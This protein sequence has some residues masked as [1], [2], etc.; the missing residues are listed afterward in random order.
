MPTPAPP[1]LWDSGVGHEQQLK[2]FIRI[3]TIIIFYLILK[4]RVQGKKLEFEKLQFLYS[5]FTF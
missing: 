3:V 2:F 5:S 1:A 4:S